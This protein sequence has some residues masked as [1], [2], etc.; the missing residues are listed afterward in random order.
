MEKVKDATAAIEGL[1]GIK[2]EG[3]SVEIK[4]SETEKGHASKFNSSIE[5]AIVSANIFLDHSLILP[6]SKNYMRM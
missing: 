1:A 2:I 5:A 4:Y 6:L 3:R